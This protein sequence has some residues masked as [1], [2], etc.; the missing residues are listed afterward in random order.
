MFR[1][2]FGGMKS[3]LSEP[4]LL[5]LGTRDSTEWKV[6]S[7]LLQSW[8]RP[9][10]AIPSYH[11][12]WEVGSAGDCGL[13]REAV[14]GEEARVCARW[15]AGEGDSQSP[16]P[17]MGPF[18]GLTLISECVSPANTSVCDPCSSRACSL[19]PADSNQLVGSFAGDN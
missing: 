12:P 17:P 9:N 4:T 8:R 2:V 18:P 19:L 3:L 14:C 6:K 5:G 16:R 11:R 1:S 13:A 10:S 15:G 7:L